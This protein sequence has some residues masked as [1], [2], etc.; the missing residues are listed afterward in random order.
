[1]NSSEYE[2][3][4][5]A[6]SDATVVFRQ[7]QQAYRARQISDVEF[8]AAKAAYQRYESEFDSAFEAETN[9]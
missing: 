8:L 3:A 9:R 6:L 1:M 4:S 5:Q 7:A 2:A